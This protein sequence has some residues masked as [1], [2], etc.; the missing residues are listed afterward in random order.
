MHTIKRMTITIYSGNRGNGIS[1]GLLLMNQSCRTDYQWK[2]M[3]ITVLK[4]VRALK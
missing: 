4:V 1:L 2:F 3:K